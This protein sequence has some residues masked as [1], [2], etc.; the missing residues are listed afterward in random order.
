MTYAAVIRWLLRAGADVVLMRAI[1]LL[2][3]ELQ[4]VT[5]ETDTDLDN[6]A[7]RILLQAIHENDEECPTTGH[8]PSSARPSESSKS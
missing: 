3:K 2:L 5:R 7:L 1:S 8:H 4:Q 6:R